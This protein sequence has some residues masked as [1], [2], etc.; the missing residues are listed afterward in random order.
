LEIDHLVP[1]ANAWRSGAYL[2]TGDPRISFANDLSYPGH[3]NAVTAELNS[4]KSDAGP[5]NWRPPAP[6]AWCPYAIDW[7]T[8]KDRWD[9]TVTPAEVAALR[10]MLR[11]CPPDM[12]TQTNAPPPVITTTPSPATS[13]PGG[14]YYANCAEARAAGAAPILRGEPGYRPALDGDS[15]GVACE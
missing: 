2:W 11:F 1:L 4:A 10:D 5:E 7:V 6:E 15:D 9:L 8:T 14:V 13:S 3:L 12:P